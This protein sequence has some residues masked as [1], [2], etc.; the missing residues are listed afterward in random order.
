MLDAPPDLTGLARRRSRK[1]HP[2]CSGDG[3]LR[4]G[5]LFVPV[6]FVV[7]NAG[8]MAGRL[9]AGVGPWRRTPPPGAALV[10]YA[11]AR[12]V[13]GAA[14]ALC[15]VNVAHTWVLPVV[16]RCA[17]SWDNLS[18]SMGRHLPVT[19]WLRAAIDFRI[20][21]YSVGDLTQIPCSLSR[22]SG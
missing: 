6:V 2:P 21:A 22:A 14:L 10:G 7:F 19:A 8:D 3:R 17:P 15:N 16:F 9:A 13:L 18:W 1:L 11:V 12:A 20:F 4:T 5:E